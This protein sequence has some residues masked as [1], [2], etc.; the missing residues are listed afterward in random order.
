M[1]EG[2]AALRM[3]GV[4]KD[5]RSLRPL[6]IESLDV[7]RGQVVA[8]MGFDQAMSEIFIDLLTGRT[9]PDTGSVTVLGRDTTDIADANAWLATLDRFGIVSERSVLVSELTVEQTLALS[10]SFVLDSLSKDITSRVADL[11]GQVELQ[12][13]L[14]RQVGALSPLGRMR[15]RLGRAVAPEPDILVLEHP[16]ASL[17]QEDARRFVDDVARVTAQRSSTRRSATRPIATVVLTADRTFAEAVAKD[18]LV[19]QPAT[20]AL[21]PPGWRQWFS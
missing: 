4:R 10:F 21:K 15:T 19:L 7:A 14:G 3:R 9:V 16:N 18:V 5:Y 12:Q 2:G 8:L 1:I 20:G 17:S 6:R 11:A 13:E